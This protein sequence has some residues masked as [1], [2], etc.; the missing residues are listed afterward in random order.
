[1]HPGEHLRRIVSRVKRWRLI[2]LL[3]GGGL[4]LLLLFLLAGVLFVAGRVSG[5][6]E[7]WRSADVPQSSTIA[8]AEPLEQTE[9][10]TCG[11]LSLSSAYRAYGLSPDN[12]NLRFRLGVDRTA[13]PVDST[14]T[15]TLHPDLLRVIVQDGFTY[16]LLDPGAS[17]AGSR[18]R[19]H[20]N[21]HQAALIL[22]RRPESGGLHW[23]L[24][25]E[26]GDGRLRIV[27]S[28]RPEPVREALD[29]FMREV[30]LSIIL[31]KPSGV[32]VMPDVSAAHRAGVA[33]MVLVRERLKRF[34]R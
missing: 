32:D 17:D 31:L 14:S 25:D 27:D 33:E 20:V 3:A 6:S 21:A 23:L 13:N 2:L 24:T 30:A 9:P 11:L 22:I 8:P 26:A 1:M 28:L 18:L 16:E 29:A 10:H 34:D 5:K 15:G 7:A 4:G 19:E 12:K